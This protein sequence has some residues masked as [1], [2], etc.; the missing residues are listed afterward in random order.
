MYLC[1]CLHVLCLHVSLFVF[2]SIMFTCTFVCVYMYL[3]L[4]LHVLCLHVHDLCIRIYSLCLVPWSDLHERRRYHCSESYEG[5]D[6]DIREDE[7]DIEDNMIDLLL[8]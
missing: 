6:E 8:D 4:C 2:T 5:S 3:Y 1:L 7:D